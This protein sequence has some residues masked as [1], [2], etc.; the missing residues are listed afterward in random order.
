MQAIETAVCFQK[1][2]ELGS[3]TNNGDNS[4]E[5]V[6]KKTGFD[7]YNVSVSHSMNMEMPSFM[8]YGGHK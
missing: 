5:K 6:V 1:E 3:F 8:C 2:R 7:K 4:N